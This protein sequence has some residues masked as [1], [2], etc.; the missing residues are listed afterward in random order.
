MFKLRI[1]TSVLLGGVGLAAYFFSSQ[2]N[3]AKIVSVLTTVLEICGNK[4]V[5]IMRGSLVV[6]LR[7]HSPE[8][9]LQ[10][11]DD[12]ELG[13]VGKRLSEAFSKIGIEEVTVEMVNE[14]VLRQRE[15]IR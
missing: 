2:A 5:E 4:I 13:K 10:F 15:V 1:N 3:K 14:E 12:Y 9:F 7:C 8:S 6:V 11:L